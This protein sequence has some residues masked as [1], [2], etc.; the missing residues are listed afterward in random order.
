MLLYWMT[1]YAVVE[2]VKSI[3]GFTVRTLSDGDQKETIE[4]TAI[5]N[6]WIRDIIYFDAIPQ[7]L[8]DMAGNTEEIDLRKRFKSK[9]D[10]ERFNEK[11]EIQWNF[12]NLRPFFIG[13]L[14]VYRVRFPYP[15]PL[16]NPSS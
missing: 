14:S 7:K 16:L 11:K 13:V 15:G 4:Y 1:Q 3:A 10:C 5:C 8:A 6:K 2:P 12:Y 9:C